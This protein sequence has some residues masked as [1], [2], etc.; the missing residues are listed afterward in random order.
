[1]N[2]RLGSLAS[3]WEAVPYSACSDKFVVGDI[4]LPVRVLC[5]GE[6]LGEEEVTQGKP[7]VGPAGRRLRSTLQK[8]GF[9]DKVCSFANV[10]PRRPIDESGKNRTPTDEEIRTNKPFLLELIKLLEPKVIL[11]LGNSPLQALV[12][13][14]K[15][16]EER[17][18]EFT[19]PDF[20]NSIILPTWHP[21]N[22]LYR[23]SAYPDFESDLRW[24]VRLLNNDVLD[25][26]DL[27]PFPYIETE[28]EY[29]LFVQESL[30]K[31]EYVYFD[32]EV[33][34][35]PPAKATWHWDRRVE[36]VL[37]SFGWMENGSPRACVLRWNE[38]TRPLIKQILEAGKKLGGQ[39]FL[40]YDLPI[41]E[42]KGINTNK[43]DTD[44]YLVARLLDE[45]DTGGL[46]QRLRNSLGLKNHTPYRTKTEEEHFH[47]QWYLWSDM[48]QEE[49]EQ[50]IHYSAIDSWGG[51]QD[52]YKLKAEF[53]KHPKL[54]RLYHNV[55]VPGCKAAVE[56]ERTGLPTNV[57]KV[58][59]LARELQRDVRRAMRAV[60][61]ALPQNAWEVV[62][63]PKPR[64]KNPIIGSNALINPGSTH[65]L[66]RVL[67]KVFGLPPVRI[68]EKGLESTNEDAL[69]KLMDLKGDPAFPP[70]A[71]EALEAILTMREKRQ[72]LNMF[73]RPWMK[74][75]KDQNPDGLWRKTKIG[76]LHGR[77]HV[78]GTDTLRLSSSEPNLQNI[79]RSIRY[80]FE[81][82]PGWIFV[83]ADFNALEVRGAADLSQ[84]PLLL[85]LIRRGEDMHSYNSRQFLGMKPD[86]EVEKGI[87]YAI[88]T[89]FFSSLYA[90]RENKIAETIRKKFRD[91]EVGVEVVKELLAQ[92][93]IKV[94]R[95]PYYALAEAWRKW[96][97][98]HYRS[99]EAWHQR[100]RRE[101]TQAGEVTSWFGFTR[102]LP[103]A[104]S[105][106][107]RSREDAVRQAIN[108]NNQQLS[109]LT[110]VNLR[111]MMRLRD[112]TDDWKAV[113]QV[114]DSI[115][116][117]AKEGKASIWADILADVMEDASVWRQFETTFSVPLVAEVSMKKTW[118]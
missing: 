45:N 82:P 76:Y 70:A 61:A 104:L 107:Y 90:A 85:R 3:R 30:E 68:T 5:V 105:D 73:I 78:A 83:S 115:T 86:A 106:D 80:V 35:T 17:G 65:Q 51:I 75:I 27:P 46:K 13:R 15:I 64:K 21:A 117:L 108:C 103:D 26:K 100:V 109:I 79:P 48:T 10:V 54:Q 58:W 31:A 14:S 88:K 16:S 34:A 11:L 28:M 42:Y 8:V 81:A 59:R 22:T 12:G 92:K 50:R 62:N 71:F 111:D 56:M 63:P 89:L 116:L 29:A 44:T 67:F 99:L 66:G 94:R 9:D 102:H 2:E 49:Q 87:R 113:A 101:V 118:A 93:K 69:L 39:N 40:Q 110:L 33:G 25:A 98:S 38:M 77:F 1:M 4:K 95:D 36:I 41:L 60:V 114:H 57:D 37:A 72:T 19:D 53:D 74:Q 18:R 24:A 112:G 7:F 23:P 52:W 32:L 96:M 97:F 84:D 6:A 20:G 43:I 47:R 91:A 55:L